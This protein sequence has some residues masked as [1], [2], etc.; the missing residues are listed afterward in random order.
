MIVVGENSRLNLPNSLADCDGSSYIIDLN[1]G[2]CCDFIWA[3]YVVGW[4]GVLVI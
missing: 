2:N 1:I 4:S 3:C